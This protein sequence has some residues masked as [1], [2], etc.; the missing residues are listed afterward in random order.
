[1]PSSASIR[2]CGAAA[3]VSG[4]VLWEVRGGARLLVP[5]HLFYLWAFVAL[6][7]PLLFSVAL[8]GLF[9]TLT[10]RQRVLGGVGLLL[11][12]M[13]LF[14][15]SCGSMWRMV[16]PIADVTFVCVYLEEKG[17]P[18][19]L[20]S[21]VPYICTALVALGLGVSRTKALGRWSLLPLL[22]GAVGLI[23]YAADFGNGIGLF[24]TDLAFSVLFELSW[25]A[26]GYLLWRQG[27]NSQ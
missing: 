15:A 21:W 4:G 5:G 9:T 19:Y 23:S 18:R 22:G 11:A 1:M 16:V 7:V 20:L 6:V 24:L 27:N 3:S 2:R 14:V 8:V 12:G 10:G 26:L 17:L 13:G 25:V